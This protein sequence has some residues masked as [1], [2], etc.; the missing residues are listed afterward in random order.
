MAAL[1]VLIVL[2]MAVVV[3]IDGARGL[4]AWMEAVMKLQAEADGQPVPPAKI[5]A[6]GVPPGLGAVIGVLFAFTPIWLFLALGTAWAL[7]SVALRGASPVEALLGG[8]RAAFVNALPLLG[9]ILALGL[10]LLLIG[11]LVMMVLG[12]LIGVISAI[13]PALGN[14]VTLLMITAISIVFAAISFGF[15]LNGWRAI[16]DDAGTAPPANAPPMAGFEA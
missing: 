10:P 14:L 16:C 9:L 11:G 4:Q 1:F 7:V 2:V 13:S 8:L 3:G 6:L 15:V 5:E 12:A